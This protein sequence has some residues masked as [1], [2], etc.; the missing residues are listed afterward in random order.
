MDEPLPLLN[1]CELLELQLLSTTD[2]RHITYRQRS[3]IQLYMFQQLIKKIGLTLMQLRGATYLRF[4]LENTA[5][6]DAQLYKLLV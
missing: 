3:A 6:E 4:W 2:G 5:A 1:A